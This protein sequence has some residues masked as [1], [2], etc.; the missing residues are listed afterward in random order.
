MNPRSTYE[1]GHAW[2]Y[3]DLRTGLGVHV[4]GLVNG[5]VNHK[6]LSR[7]LHGLATVPTH[8]SQSNYKCCMSCFLFIILYCFCRN[9]KLNE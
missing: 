8:I 4:N 3:E 6:V 7:H 5:G 2:I 9:P 1:P